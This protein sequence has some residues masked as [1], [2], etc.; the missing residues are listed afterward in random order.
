[1]NNPYQMPNYTPYTNNNLQ[2][3]PN[4]YEELRKTLDKIQRELEHIE[5][6][7]N[8]IENALKNKNPNYLSTGVGNEKGLYMI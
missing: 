1:M 2:P 8:Q 6:R 5:K 7:L 4:I 3:Y